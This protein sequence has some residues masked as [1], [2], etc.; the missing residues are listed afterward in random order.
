M[1]LMLRHFLTQIEDKMD[2]IEVGDIIEI[3]KNSEEYGSLHE[4][5]IGYEYE[6]KAIHKGSEIDLYFLLD[7]D[8]HTGKQFEEGVY[9]DE[10][11]FIKKGK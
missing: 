9:I 11:K 10:I 7:F 3:I 4:F 8:P 6:V 5:R 2:K 1:V